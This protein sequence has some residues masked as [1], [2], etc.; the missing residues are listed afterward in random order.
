MAKV[1]QMKQL[2]RDRVSWG[3]P[4]TR[5]MFVVDKDHSSRI[6][7]NRMKLYCLERNI[8]F[9]SI[10]LARQRERFEKHIKSKPDCL[11]IDELDVKNFDYVCDVTRELS[12][13]VCVKL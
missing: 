12:Q 3:F 7:E 9:H 11:V 13:V 5:L 8:D 1:L 10:Y 2:C 4:P 6:F